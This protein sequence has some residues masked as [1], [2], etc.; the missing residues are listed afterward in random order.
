MYDLITAED[1]TRVSSEESLDMLL[2]ELDSLVGLVDVKRRVREMIDVAC[3]LITQAAMGLYRGDPIPK[4][5]AFMGNIGTGKNTV[6]R[7]FAKIYRSLGILKT[8]QFVE[9]DQFGLVGKYVGDGGVVSKRT[10][11]IV[12]KAIG[13]VLFVNDAWELDPRRRGNDEALAELIKAMKIHRG[14]FAVILAGC[15]DRM[16]TFLKDTGLG[17]YY[18]RSDTRIQFGNYTAD[19]LV[20]IFL[21]MAEKKNTSPTFECLE[22]VWNHYRKI[23]ADPPTRFA[24]ADDVRNLFEIAYSNMAHRI[25]SIDKPK[26]GQ[27]LALLPADLPVE[28]R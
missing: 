10:K 5:L 3:R 11:A 12:D 18:F 17:R 21:F 9:T 24:N 15:Q 19:E 27:F 1:S 16:L 20:R 6:G 14:D 28:G 7:L 2:A 22:A 23:L 25:M 4:R 26:V 13:G 8:G